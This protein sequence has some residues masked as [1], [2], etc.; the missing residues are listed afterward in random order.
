MAPPDPS[1]LLAIGMFD[2]PDM[3][4]AA[5]T[6]RESAGG[7]RTTSRGGGNGGLWD[8]SDS[9]AEGGRYRG[10]TPPISPAQVSNGNYIIRR[11]F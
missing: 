3:S 7:Q 8:D 10:L 5:Y 6:G 4:R 9:P 1:V 2:D 11:T